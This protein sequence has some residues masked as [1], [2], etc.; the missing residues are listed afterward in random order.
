MLPKFTGN[1]VRFMGRMLLVTVRLG[2]GV[3]CLKKGVRMSMTN[4]AAVGLVSSKTIW[5]KN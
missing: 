4:S 3:V 2:N 5:W 1:F